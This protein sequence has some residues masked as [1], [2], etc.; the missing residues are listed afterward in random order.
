MEISNIQGYALSSPIEPVQEQ[1]FHGGTR[2]LKKRDIVLVVETKNGARGRDSRCEQLC[3]DRVLRGRF[4]RHLR[5]HRYSAVADAL[6]GETISEISEVHDLLRNSKL[7]ADDLTEAISAIDVTVYD[8]RGKEQ[9]T[10]VYELLAAEYNATPSTELP[11]YASVGIDM[12]PEGYVEQAEIIENLGFFGYKYRPGI[13]PD[14]D[15]RTIGLLTK[16]I[17]DTRSCSIPTLGGN[18]RNSTVGT[19]TRSDRTR[20]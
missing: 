17:E 1:S 15:R 7:P 13:G 4:P 3:H 18:S 8:I 12:K 9:D 11:L 5:G 16:E 20:L 2:R 6:E 10:P 14:G 19:R